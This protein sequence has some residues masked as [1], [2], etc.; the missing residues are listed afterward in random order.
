MAFVGTMIGVQIISIA[1]MFSY[2]AGRAENTPQ[3][4]DTPSAITAQ[5]Q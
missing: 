2:L 5:P 1:A 4:T 3:P